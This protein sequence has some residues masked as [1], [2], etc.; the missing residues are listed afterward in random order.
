MSGERSTVSEEERLRLIRPTELIERL[1]MS[2]ERQGCIPKDISWEGLTCYYLFDIA[3]S[4]RILL[5]DK[6]ESSV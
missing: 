4:L 1:E 5:E 3:V 2:I 6:E